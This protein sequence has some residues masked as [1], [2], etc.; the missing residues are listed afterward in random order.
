LKEYLKEYEH[1]KE[2]ESVKITDN[3]TMHRIEAK[4]KK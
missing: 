2:G 4:N 1:V 3:I